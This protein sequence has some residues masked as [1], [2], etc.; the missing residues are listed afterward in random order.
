MSVALQSNNL[1][2]PVV[3]SLTHFDRA[4]L[5]QAGG[6]GANLGELIK[7]GFD[8]P[9][10]FII[11]TA[12]YDLLLQSNELQ[13]KIEQMVGLLII[14]NPESVAEISRQIR[15]AIQYASIPNL[16]A[17]SALKAYRQ[18]K[19]GAVAIRSSATAEDLP[20]AAF[21]GQQET[22]LNVI[23]EQALLDAVR[24]C[25]ASL[26]SE[27][28]IFYRARQ[29]VDQVSVKLAVVVQKMVPADVA[30]VMFTANPVSGAHDEL[31]IDASPGLGEAVVSGLVTPDHFIVSKSRLRIKEFR[32][33]RREVIIHS[34]AEGGTEQV[35]STG[36]N[37]EAALSPSAVRN[38]AR[39]GKQIERH[40]GTPQDIE[41][42]W[43]EEG[44]KA[45]K[46]LIL[47]ARPMTA[48]P[49]PVKLTAPIRMVIPMLAE[50]WII[51]PYPLDMTTFTGTIERAIGNLLVVM[52]GKSAPEPDKALVE[53]DGVVTHFE[54]PAV[55]PSISMLI[56]PWLALW[57]TRYYD[58]SRWQA[59]P[60]IHEVLAGARELEKRNLQSLTWKQNIETL[61]ESLALIP[62][63]MQL[64]ER[65]I[66]KALMGLGKLWLLLV[67]SR[68]KNHFSQLISGVET[69]TTET[70]RAL[71]TLA[72]PIR[73]DVTLRE[74]FA[75]VES[76]EL[77]SELPRSEAGQGFLQKFSAFLAQYGHRETALTISQPAWK[78]EPRIVLGILKV[79]ASSELQR[80]DR[81]QEWKRE[82]DE[83]LAH[84]ILGWW[85]LRRLFLKSLTDG[86]AFFQL[87]E[88]THF[89]ATL[90]QPL[91]RRVALELGN[92]VEQVGAIKSATDIFHLRLDE[93]EKL[94][95]SWPPPQETITQIHE[96]VSRRNA[97]RESLMS[98][99]MV[100][101]RLLA[102]PLQNQMDEEIILRGSPGSPGTASGPARIV[103]DVSEFGKLQPGEILVAPATNPAWTPLFQRAAAVVVDM[104][105]AASHA[106]I[107]AR[108]YGVPA[109]MGT[110]DGTRT[111]TDGQWI[112]VDGSRGLVWRATEHNESSR[113]DL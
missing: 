90:A 74:L 5:A 43:M 104:G 26:W 87:R 109:V 112:L 47:Q 23:G 9:P 21:A 67:M 95:E 30:G 89:Y 97:K 33:G 96:L 105:G 52:I 68:H 49:K 82:R 103:R 41:W 40:Y 4:S 88:D 56:S 91:V 65:Y 81:Y 50:M 14:D 80:T 36:K 79:L 35:T 110:F 38:L 1:N 101:P 66:P 92:R 46:F 27:R 61:Q 34:K 45:G 111:L 57:R 102:S 15:D 20:E 16:I 6:K 75:Q 48:L 69:K 42:A 64:R 18:L 99:P 2:L 53:E 10:G 59:D 100:D 7:A 106:A 3:A 63:V 78:D 31:V 37:K 85:P 29:N 19:G 73:G 55:H 12:A 113:N 25:W 58:P 44:T 76:D 39:L 60:I 28:A 72:L 32:V 93:L 77:V 83:L 17:D 22:F 86:R 98:K 62:R 107:V 70:N 11:T 94:G 24:S 84:S 71:E 108:E 54:P 51:R 13:A 8:V